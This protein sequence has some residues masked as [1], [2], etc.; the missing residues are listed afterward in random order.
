MEFLWLVG[1]LLSFAE[2]PGS[3]VICCI[4]D[5]MGLLGRVGQQHDSLT[6]NFHLLKCGKCINRPPVSQTFF[7]K[8]HLSSILDRIRVEG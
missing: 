1:H 7:T 8:N 6:L 4:P 5:I 2:L 3:S